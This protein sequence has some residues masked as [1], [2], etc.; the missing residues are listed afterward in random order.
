MTSNTGAPVTLPAHCAHSVLA[1][2]DAK[3]NKHQPAQLASHN[4]LTIQIGIGA[5]TEHS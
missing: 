1:V 2:D 5:C 4:Q 3:P